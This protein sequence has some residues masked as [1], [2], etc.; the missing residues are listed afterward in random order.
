MERDHFYVVN[1]DG[2]WNVKH[3]DSYFGP[4]STQQAAIAE[5]VQR[6][7]KLHATSGNTQV[8]VEGESAT[9]RI[10]WPND[11]NRASDKQG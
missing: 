10:E 3:G 4:Y 5:A 11:T 2:A 9:F 8:M 7:H 6:A 1:K